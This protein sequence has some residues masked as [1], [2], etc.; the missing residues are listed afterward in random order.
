[1]SSHTPT[2]R[3]VRRKTIQ[4]IMHVGEEADRL[5]QKEEVMMTLRRI[6]TTPFAHPPVLQE[7]KRKKEQQEAEEQRLRD[8]REARRQADPIASDMHALKRKKTEME[9]VDVKSLNVVSGSLSCC[10]FPHPTL[11]GQEACGR[12]QL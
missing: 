11:K 2:V 10:H 6:T 1:M 9:P 7:E 8:E 3:F 4:H 5:K 12:A